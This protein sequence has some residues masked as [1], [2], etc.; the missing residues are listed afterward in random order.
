MRSI[1]KLFTRQRLGLF[2]FLAIG[3]IGIMVGQMVFARAGGGDNYVPGGGSSGGEYGGGGGGDGG[4]FALLFALIFSNL[5]APLKF[6]LLVI[7]IALFVYGA[8]KGKVRKGLA[9]L[10]TNLP[11]T[12]PPSNQIAPN[13]AGQIAELKNRDPNF[14]E[15]QFEDLASTAFSKIQTAWSKRDM[16]IAQAFVS[17]TLLQRFQAQLNQ[18]KSQ[19]K[20]NKIENLAVGKVEIVEA[21]QDG[22][23]DYITV[24][25]DASA[26]DYYVDEK[27][28]KILS[29]TKELK[30]FTEFWTF[31][32]SGEVKT[33]AGKPELVSR[34]CPNCGAPMQVNAI[35]KCEYC[36]SELSSG[37]FSWVLSEISQ[38]S[39]F[40]PRAQAVRPQNISPLAGNRYVLGLVQCPNC[41]ANVQDIAGITTER[42]WRC[43]GVVQT[44]Q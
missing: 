42:C 10:G 23:F 40:R 5:P 4:L 36:G 39:V 25:I 28:G 1:Y 34:H 32:R 27:S 31:L 29:G 26:S 6:L 35:G 16:S 44:K 33:P 20:I 2:I 9:S 11:S 12:Y 24:R 43:G 37:H 18:L 13:F 15:Q 14:S 41:G 38:A 8:R 30:P 3:L 17:P 19:G 21:V 7:L 22:G